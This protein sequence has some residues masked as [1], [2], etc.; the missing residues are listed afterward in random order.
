MKEDTT[1]TR[2][3]IESFLYREARLLDTQKFEDWLALFD[4]DA[5]YWV[6]AGRD[7]IDP[8]RHVSIIHDDKPAMARRV[9]RLRSGFAFAQEPASR[10]H[11]IVSNVDLVEVDA[12]QV[13]VH[14]MLL[15]VELARHRQ[16]LHSAHC[17]FR[18]RR[19][20]DAWRIARK[21]VNLLGNDEALPCT[22]F[23]L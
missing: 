18:L 19:H 23:L 16:T 2:G 4:E 6:P 21:K 15:L 17:E 22:P 9:K 5:L 13:E 10:I 7:D 12:A 11:R 3:D 1:P 14:C 8:R 20:G